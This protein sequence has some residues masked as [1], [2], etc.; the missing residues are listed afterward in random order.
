MKGINHSIEPKIGDLINYLFK[1]NP[2]LVI[3]S[4]TEPH[5][6]RFG[7]EEIDKQGFERPVPEGFDYTVVET[8][9]E[10]SPYIDIK[11]SEIR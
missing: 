10:F 5:K 1:D 9:V 2:C 6:Q 8:G 3:A 11:V 4:K 7:N